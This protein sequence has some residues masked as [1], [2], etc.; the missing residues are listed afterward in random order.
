[1]FRCCI[2]GFWTKP[3][4]RVFGEL[5]GRGR[6]SPSPGRKDLGCSGWTQVGIT[7]SA[8][9]SPA[10]AGPGSSD[11]AGQDLGSEQVLGPVGHWG[12]QGWDVSPQEQVRNCI[13]QSKAGI[14]QLFHHG[15]VPCC[16]SW[17]SSKGP[18]NNQSWQS[19]ASRTGAVLGSQLPPLLI[20]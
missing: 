10:P 9:G 3:G 16:S 17:V 12:H 20:P 11:R 13:S 2:C 15:L 14:S 6:Q 8:R 7:C 18:G 4:L 1:M 19:S 5:L